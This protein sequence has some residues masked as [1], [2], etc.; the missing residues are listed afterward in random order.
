[1]IKELGLFLATV[2]VAI[3]LLFCVLRFSH[4]YI[5]LGSEPLFE[6]ILSIV[7][8]FIGI[9]SVE[10]Y[11]RPFGGIFSISLS[12]VLKVS[13]LSL[14]VTMFII[15]WFRVW[16]KIEAYRRMEI[17]QLK[18]THQYDPYYGSI[19]NTF[20]PINIFL[21]VFFLPVLLMRS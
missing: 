20:F 16:E 6:T 3:L 1:M 5:K 13:L 17:I 7:N 4:Y 18:G 12:L 11:H 10:Q 9:T 15:R 19:S 8:S 14:L 21:I 2:G